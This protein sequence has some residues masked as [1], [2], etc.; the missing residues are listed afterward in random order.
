[1]TAII[2]ALVA[3]LKAFPALASIVKT[4]AS[5]YD[6]W[7]TEQDAADAEANRNAR[8]VERDEFFK[9][10]SAGAANPPGLPG[11]TAQAPGSRE[12]GVD[13]SKLVSPGN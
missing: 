12:S 3:L 8:T 7:K 6:K 9:R 5:E 2:A 4:V 10:V 13:L 11:P 1:M